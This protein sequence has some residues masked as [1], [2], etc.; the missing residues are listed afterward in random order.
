MRLV[1][2]CHPGRSGE[3]EQ[4]A[5]LADALGGIGEMDSGHA[6]FLGS[7]KVGRSVV[8]DDALAWRDAKLVGGDEVDGSVRLAGPG[9]AGNDHRI[10]HA[11]QVI[12]C[13][14]VVLARTPRVRQQANPDACCPGAFD[15]VQHLGAGTQATERAGQEA[16]VVDTEEP[17]YD[18]LEVALG[19]LAGLDGLDR[20]PAFRIVEQDAGERAGIEALADAERGQFG[21]QVRRDNAA[22]IEDEASVAHAV[23][24]G[25]RWKFVDNTDRGVKPDHADGD[26]SPATV[27]FVTTEHFTLQ[28]ARSSTISESTSRASVFLGAVSGGLIALGLVATAAKTGVAFYMFGLILLPTLAFVGL[29]TFHRVL[30]TGTEDLAYARRIARLRDYYFDHAPELAG[31]LPNPAEPLPTPGLG[32][33]L[34]QQFVTVAGMVA[35]ITSVLAGSAG[36]LLV[37]VAFGHSLGAALVVGVIVAAAALT[38]LMRYQNSTWIRGSTVSEAVPT[39][40]IGRV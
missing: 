24:L 8:G 27:T 16:V 36:G 12:G 35:V 9:V 14:W 37:A 23:S 31:Y 1:G 7:R 20:L 26:P 33:R 30:Q 3:P 6:E 21:E 15:Q 19:D 13:I 32:I 10:E 11:V 38:A 5:D 4:A 18:H 39:L 40:P 17:A 29:A 2:A 25:G 28:G 34:W 22:E